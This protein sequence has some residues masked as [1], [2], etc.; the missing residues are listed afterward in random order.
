MEFLRSIA[1]DSEFDVYSPGRY[2]IRHPVR[3]GMFIARAT[4][5][6]EHS[7]RSAISAHLIA[8]QNSRANRKTQTRALL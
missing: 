7:F 5:N 1:L 3:G 8:R 4:H 6:T 2:N